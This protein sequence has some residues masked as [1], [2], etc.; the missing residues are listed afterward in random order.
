MENQQPL[1]L[2]VNEGLTALSHKLPSDHQEEDQLREE[3][4]LSD[5]KAKLRRQPES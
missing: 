3:A 5:G 4:G 1:F 2:D